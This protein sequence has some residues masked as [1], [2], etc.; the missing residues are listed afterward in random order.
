MTKRPLPLQRL[1][2]DTT[3]TTA[4]AAVERR[5]NS[6]TKPSPASNTANW[7]TPT[8]GACTSSIVPAVP[9]PQARQIPIKKLFNNRPFTPYQIQI[10]KAWR[11]FFYLPPRGQQN[12]KRQ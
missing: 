4:S 12:M 1:R 8:T 3:T 9:Q 11:V 5:A 10:T 6:S 7:K 2:E